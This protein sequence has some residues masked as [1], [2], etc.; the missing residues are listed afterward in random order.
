MK[1][2]WIPLLF[3]LLAASAGPARAFCGFYVSQADARIFNKA[4]RVALAR[5][6]DR[7]VVTMSS[8]FKGDPREFAVVVPVPTVITREQVHIGDSALLDHLDSFSAPRLVEYFDSDPCALREQREM[9]AP[10]AGMMMKMSANAP[11]SDDALGVKI[12]ARYTVGEYDILILSATQSSGLGTWLKREGYRMPPGAE[13]VLG[14]YIRQG[15]HFF[16][17]RVNLKEHSKLGFETLRPIQVAY[18]SPKFM[19]PIR[20]GT[21]NADGPQDLLVFVITRSGRVESTNYRNVKVPTGMDIPLYVKEEFGRFYRAA[22]DR[23]V[24]AASREAVFTEYA[25]PM[26]WCDPCAAPPLSEEELRGLGVFWVEDAGIRGGG[27]A[28][29]FLT[30][31]HVRYDREH[32]PEDLVFLETSDAQS[33]Q[34]RYVLRHPWKGSADGCGEARAYYEQLRRRKGEEARSLAALTGWGMGDIRRRMSVGEDAVGA[35]SSGGRRWYER[36]WKN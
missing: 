20:L 33:F 21:V 2:I 23:Q 19:L 29:V 5:D 34:A 28:P 32:F 24:E 35:T 18:E 13:G 14:S 15:M 25:W 11:R 30:R 6:G 16:V 3:L 26:S 4:S 31:L 9:S 36:I 1:R 27:L 12:E 22:F 17:A 8:D 7:A 10:A